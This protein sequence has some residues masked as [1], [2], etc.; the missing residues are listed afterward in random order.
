[1]HALKVI[2]ILV[3][4]CLNV[5]YYK[6]CM[7]SSVFDYYIPYQTQQVLPFFFNMPIT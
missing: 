5:C 7:K 1:M 2:V 4:C 3:I 6:A